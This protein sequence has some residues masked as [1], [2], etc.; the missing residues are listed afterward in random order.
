VAAK[1]AEDASLRV[2]RTRGGLGE[3]RVVVDGKEAY[4]SNR[5]WY[6]TASSVVAHVRKFMTKST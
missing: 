1:L 5:L 4:D 3:L 2:T 6:P